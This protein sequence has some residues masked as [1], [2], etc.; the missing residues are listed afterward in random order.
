MANFYSGGC[1]SLTFVYCVDQ[2]LSVSFDK[3]SPLNALFMIW[4]QGIVSVLAW[5]LK[6]DNTSNFY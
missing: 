4:D 3:Y 5:C 6:Y 2:M 1:F